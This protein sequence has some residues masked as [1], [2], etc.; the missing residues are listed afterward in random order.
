MYGIFFVGIQEEYDISVQVMLREFNMTLNTKIK[1][2]RDQISNQLIT[3]QKAAIKSNET[4]LSRLRLVNT[5][6]VQLYKIGE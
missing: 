1:K 3:V 6:D 5:Y 4:L 2:E